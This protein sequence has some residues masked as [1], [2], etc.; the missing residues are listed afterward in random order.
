MSNDWFYNEKLNRYEC[1]G[2]RIHGIVYQDGEVWRQSVFVK[3]EGEPDRGE[4]SDRETAIANANSAIK[5]MIW[6]RRFQTD[7]PSIPAGDNDEWD[8]DFDCGDPDD[9]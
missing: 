6:H 4:W 5:R 1:Q 9:D 8:D 7:C 2:T 3:G